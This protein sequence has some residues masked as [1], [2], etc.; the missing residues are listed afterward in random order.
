MKIQI[1][2]HMC[3]LCPWSMGVGIGSH[4][5]ELYCFSINL[6]KQKMSLFISPVGNILLSCCHTIKSGRRNQKESFLKIFYS[7]NQV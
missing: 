4:P 5:M 7:E 2:E 1:L 3:N 6:H